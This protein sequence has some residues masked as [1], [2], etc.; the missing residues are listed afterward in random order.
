M[1][2]RSLAPMSSLVLALAACVGDD[3]LVDTDTHATTGATAST[4]SDGVSSTGATT[5][6][7]STTDASTSTGETSTSATSTGET[8]T[9]G[10]PICGDGVVEGPEVC[11][12]GNQCSNDGCDAT[13]SSNAGANL[14]FDEYLGVLRERATAYDLTRTPAGNLVVVGEEVDVDPK[15]LV[16]WAREYTPDGALVWSK[17]VDPT[18]V[19]DT[20]LAVAAAADGD[21]VVGGRSREPECSDGCDLGY[22]ARLDPAGSLLWSTPIPGT[23]A[24]LDV[25][26]AGDGDLYVAGNFEDLFT[27]LRF[28][29]LDADGAVLWIQDPLPKHDHLRSAQAI[30][31]AGDGSLVVG[32]YQWVE[33]PPPAYDLWYARLTP[34]GELLWFRT[35]DG[36]GGG[37]DEIRDVALTGDGD[38]ILVGKIGV[39]VVVEEDEIYGP[40]IG[41]ETSLLWLARADPDG[42]LLWSTALDEVPGSIGLDL[43][44]LPDRVV[45]AGASQLQG[46]C[47]VNLGHATFTPDGALLGW[48]KGPGTVNAVEVLDDGTPGG[49]VFLAGGNISAWVGRYVGLAP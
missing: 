22:V 10:G 24:V 29:R 4:S 2:W 33:G 16:G 7:T 32:G 44:V 38:L 1:G 42:E 9:T 26:I 30:A 25:E 35:F 36:G 18:P 13:C 43:K 5:P 48:S 34:A 45:V 39:D 41:S 27:G 46:P 49:A 12:D 3:V 40:I 14:W 19:A 6:S 17:A 28:G 15:K 23:S 11:D 47:M 8:T 21:L 37:N 20:L 31:I